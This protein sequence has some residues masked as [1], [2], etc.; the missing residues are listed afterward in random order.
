MKK[1]IKLL[2][3]MVMMITL[4]GCGN[5]NN[6]GISG[7]DSIDTLIK[8]Y[9]KIY[10]W[11]QGSEDYEYLKSLKNTENVIIINP[12]LESYR[13]I[14]QKGNIDYVGTRLHAGIYAMANKVRSIIISIDNRAQDM[15]ETY[16]INTINKDEIASLD[17]KINSEFKTNIN[18]DQEKINEWKNQFKK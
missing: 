5:S 6:G 12:T 2:L 1:T 15:A 16:N 7:N 3:V 8:N 10:F 17:S 9:E 13:E 18:I 4:V 11:V 14:L